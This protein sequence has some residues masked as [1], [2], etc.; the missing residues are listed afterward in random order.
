[1]EWA[2]NEGMVPDYAEAAM[3]LTWGDYAL[4]MFREFGPE[5]NKDSRDSGLLSD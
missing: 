5:D 2:K 4:L 3:P 1:M